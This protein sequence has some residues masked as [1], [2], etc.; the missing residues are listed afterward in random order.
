MANAGVGGPT[1]ASDWSGWQRILNVNMFGVI[2]INQA[3]IPLIKSHQLPS[4]IINTGS[5]QGITTPPGSGP[6]Y[7]V[8][9]AAVKVFTEQLAHEMRSEPSTS[10]IEPKL[11]IP[12]WVFTG[13]SGGNTAG[14]TKP[15]GAW[16]SEQTVDYMLKQIQKGSFYIVC[17]DNDTPREVDLKRMEVS[18][19]AYNSKG[20]MIG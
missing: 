6:A 13:L 10:V 15:D 1:K 8:S 14:K 11:L 16:T 20:E 2:N 3:F 19:L 7:N 17:P 12:G 18:T 9:K 4:L 5:K